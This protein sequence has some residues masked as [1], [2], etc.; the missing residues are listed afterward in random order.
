MPCKLVAQA[1]DVHE[2]DSSLPSELVSSVT[3]SIFHAATPPVT[4]AVQNGAVTRVDVNG[5]SIEA[6]KGRNFSPD[7][8]HGRRNTA[9]MNGG[10]RAT[11]GS[12]SMQVSSTNSLASSPFLSAD[13]SALTSPAASPMEQMACKVSPIQV[14]QVHPGKQSIGCADL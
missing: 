1:I 4:P 14:S 11:G 13:G 2:Q 8:G 6:V 9:A 3:A 10:V 7:P 12:R 5:K